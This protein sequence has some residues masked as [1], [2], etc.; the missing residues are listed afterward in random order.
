MSLKRIRAGFTLIELLVVVAII[1]VLIAI[2]LPSLG[3][4][5]N[6][7]KQAKCAANLH[8]IGE[9]FA[10]YAAD[11][12]QTIMPYAWA[13]PSNP[14]N[15]QPYGVNTSYWFPE[16]SEWGY[17]S[18]AGTLNDGHGNVIKTAK[19]SVFMCPSGLDR[20]DFTYTD[21]T[22]P[23]VANSYHVEH[24]TQNRPY[25]CNYLMCSMDPGVGDNPAS[26]PFYSWINDPGPNLGSMF[27]GRY[28]LTAYNIG[29]AKESMVEQ[30]SAV[31]IMSD[32][33]CIFTYG[34]FG[35]IST[36]HGNNGNTAANWL[37]MDGHAATLKKGTYPDLTGNAYNPA[38]TLQEHQFEVRVTLRR[39]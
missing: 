7:G 27:P 10:T 35:A 1:S 5:R 31:G 22:P 37:F 4:A 36:R 23:D 21:P 18:Q 16:M 3:A 13:N 9:G 8:A 29:Y 30:P 25:Q 12:Q 33:F 14:N 32:G 19:S 34:N 15:G 28:P 2:L 17:L 11:Y 20:V 24:D 6:Q 26:P 39:L 38:P